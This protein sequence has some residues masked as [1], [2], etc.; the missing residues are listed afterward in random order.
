[1]TFRVS[2]HREVADRDL[3]SLGIAIRRR[4]FAANELELLSEPDKFGK[5]L[6]SPLAAFRTL[7]VGDYRTVYW[8]KGKTVFILTVG[9][10]RNAYKLATESLADDVQW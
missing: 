7:R 8:L 4:V 5:P 10:R 9:H 2:Y 3:P 1:M 6:R